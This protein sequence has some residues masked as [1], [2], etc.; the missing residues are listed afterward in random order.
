MSSSNKLYKHVFPNFHCRF[1]L[2]Y[3]KEGGN[4]YLY[5][6][7]F[8]R[9]VIYILE[10]KPEV[11]EVLDLMISEYRKCRKNLESRYSSD[12]RPL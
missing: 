3:Y 12:V 10:T 4:S 9:A 11:R 6:Q 8:Y 5:M 7:V 1:L 2:L